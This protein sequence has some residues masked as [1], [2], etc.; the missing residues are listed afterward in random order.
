MF[1]S[2]TY[3]D[4]SAKHGIVTI[5]QRYKLRS[6]LSVCNILF[7]SF[8]HLK[9]PDVRPNINLHARVLECAKTE[10]FFCRHKS[11]FL[12][13]SVSCLISGQIIFFPTLFSYS[14]NTRKHV[15]WRHANFILISLTHV[16]LFVV[17]SVFSLILVERLTILQQ[18]FQFTEKI[19]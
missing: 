7:A 15:A 6:Y 1:S 16:S 10:D 18:T 3:R 12:V 14:T 19:P 2:V 17:H 11:N 9:Y 13:S 5:L 4:H 8:K